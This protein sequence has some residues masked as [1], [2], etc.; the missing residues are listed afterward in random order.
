MWEIKE[1]KELSTKELFDIYKL[2][3]KVFVLEQTRLYKEVDDID[4]EAFHI[5]KYIDDELV[6]YARVF[7]EGDHISFGRVVTEHSQRGTGL[8]KSLMHEVLGF[9]KRNFPGSRIEIEAQ[10][11]VQKFYEKFK[12]ERIGEEFLF[13]T[14]PHVKMVLQM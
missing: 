9:I 14:T 10:T 1:F 12:F 4:L 3:Q 2:R 6:A 5:F 13:N 8:G 7:K 11:Y